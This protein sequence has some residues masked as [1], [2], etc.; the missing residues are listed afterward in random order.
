M[1]DLPREIGSAWNTPVGLRLY[2]QRGEERRFVA[3]AQALENRQVQLEVVLLPVEH[4]P[5]AARIRGR[6]A[7]EG[8][9]GDFEQV[10][11]GAQGLQRR[12]ECS[13]GIHFGSLQERGIDHVQVVAQLGHRHARG[14]REAIAQDAALQIVVE[15]RGD[16]RVFEAGHDDDF[17]AEL[18]V[19]R[20]H[21][22]QALAQF[23]LLGGIEIVDDQ[24][25]EVGAQFARGSSFDRCIGRNHRIVFTDLFDCD[26]AH[27]AATVA[28]ADE[29]AHDPR[30]VALQ[31]AV[32][33]ALEQVRKLQ[34][35][36]FAW[37]CPVVLDAQQQVQGLAHRGAQCV[38]GCFVVA[39]A[40]QRSGLVF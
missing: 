7:A 3:L 17:V 12:T 8:V 1:I 22:H 11:L 38:H 14:D 13:A 19:G 10:Q 30:G 26:R 23:L 40:R 15:H 4:A 20:A 33:A 9:V 5:E 37:E 36:V 21:L 34:A 29:Q 27:I 6:D 18:V 32:P 24:Q 16:H 39:R 35:R 31:R 25:F 28:V 2:S